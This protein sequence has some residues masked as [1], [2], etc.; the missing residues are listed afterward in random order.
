MDTLACHIAELGARAHVAAPLWLRLEREHARLVEEERAV[1]SAM[2]RA[3]RLRRS[4]DRA[5]AP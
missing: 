5:A 2:E 3:A 4:S 1:A